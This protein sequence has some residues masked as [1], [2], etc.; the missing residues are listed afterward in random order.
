MKGYT[1][2]TSTVSHYGHSGGFKVHRYVDDAGHVCAIYDSTLLAPT[3]VPF[4]VGSDGT[5]TIVL[6]MSDP[7]HPVKTANLVTPAMQS[8]HE[9]LNLNARRGL[10]AAAWG[11]PATAPAQVDLYSVKADCRHPELTASLPI[12]GLGH[13][14]GFAPDGKTFYVSAT[15]GQTLT[16]IDVTNPSL[17]V[18]VAVKVGV[19]YHGLRLSPDGRTMYVADIGNTQ[20]NGPV[21]VG[22]LTILDVSE[23]QDRDLNP[24]FH[25][26]STLPWRSM[27]IPQAADPVVIDGR[28]YVVEA[29]EFANFT[30]G[31]GLVIDGGYEADAPVGAARIIDVEDPETPHVVS[32]LRLAVHQLANRSTAQKSD[33]GA[34]L[35]VQGYAGHYCSVP[36][37]ENPGIVACSMIASGLRIFDVRDP[38]HPVEVGYFNKPTAP[39]SEPLK[40]GAWAMSAPAYDLEAP[41]GL[42]HR[43]DPRLL[44]GPAGQEHRAS[45]LLGLT[46]TIGQGGRHHLAAHTQEPDLAGPVEAAEQRDR[47]LRDLLGVA[48]GLVQGEAALPGL[49]GHVAHLHRDP[50]GRTALEREVVGD[51][52]RQAARLDG[53]LV[54]VLEVLLE[55]GLAPVRPR[56]PRR[57]VDG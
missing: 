3:D 30:V 2:N 28:H 42:V 50:R 22:G 47:G 15:S 45:A 16:A 51:L 11:N 48:G 7:R 5:G 20:P 26:I 34:S 40:E 19:N 39:G 54:P 41:D 52:G 49:E 18:P 13:E 38:E 14:S 25:T 56:D 24:Q 21:A 53:H 35:P 17:P 4:N 32:N 27:S 8:P 9:S 57:R 33:P 31:P 29:D 23:I 36:R 10:L 43:R 37:S 1:C 6:D 12:G 46:A 55:R 44:R